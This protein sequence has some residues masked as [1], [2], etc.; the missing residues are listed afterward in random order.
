[1]FGSRLCVVEGLT[2]PDPIMLLDDLGSLD[3]S[4]V[5]P[6]L[7]FMLDRALLLF[8]ALVERH[9][10]SDSLVELEAILIIV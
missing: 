10:A 9:I 2:L 6:V 3:V 7:A 1:M 5:V 4:R 8:Q